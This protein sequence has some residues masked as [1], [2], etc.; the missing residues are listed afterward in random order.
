M[1]RTSN[2]AALYARFSS[3]NQRSESIDAQVRAMRSY[4]AQHGILIVDTY[5]DEA[6]SA[7]TDRRPAFQKMIADSALHTFN[8]VLVH[9]LDRFAR[10]RYDSAIYKRELKENGVR[11]YSVLENLDDSP[12]SIMMESV[13]EGMSEFYSCNLA[14]ESMKGLRENALKC[15][16]TG[17]KPPLGYDIDPVTKQMILNEEEAKAVR[18]IFAM[19]AD[20]NGYSEIL[21]A[22]HRENMLTKNGNEFGKNSLY[23]I[24]TNP[25]YQGTYVFNR[26]SAKS[27]SG[28]R[29]SHLLKN[30]EEIIAIENGCPRIIDDETFNIVQKRLESHRHTGGR[31]NAK[32]VYLLSGK[33]FCK[34][35]G[36]AMVGNARCAGRSKE[37]YITYR[38]PSRN[39]QCSN[40]EINRAYLERYVVTLLE[41][42]IFN[43]P[44]LQK[45]RKQIL[46]LSESQEERTSEQ[47]R[48]AET[49][50]VEITDAID[51]ITGVIA[52]G[53]HSDAL[54]ERLMALE[55]E[56]ALLESSLAK[57]SQSCCDRGKAMIEPSIILE[58][59]TS[60]RAT[61]SLPSYR[62]FLQEFIGRIEVGR[63]GLTI[64]LKTDLDIAPELDTCVSVRRQEIYE[65]R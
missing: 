34:E 62:T 57:L 55:K 50:L 52:A 43:L 51:N 42:H 1:I 64:E 26:S 4:C 44:A 5:I 31:N 59:Y 2:R 24:L 56:K 21:D 61:P 36:R 46:G 45:I 6:K 40:R 53:L 13:L 9:K 30:S 65:E 63:Y 35:C 47:V 20:G 11:V 33:V 22:L 8:I 29:N 25:K 28:T 18:L 19:Y 48:A 10:N 23:S 38:C 12:E 32:H 49:K 39:Y 17:G 41:T 54:L 58:E 16:H 7:T 14:R 3:D 27:V 15:K 60:I 37:L